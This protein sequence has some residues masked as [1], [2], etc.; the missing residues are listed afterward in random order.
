MLRVIALVSASMLA[1]LGCDS[2]PAQP[3]S[4]QAGSARAV[5]SQVA[6]PAG[7]AGSAGSTGSAGSAT[8]ASPKTAAEQVQQWAPAGTKVAPADLKVPGV[9]LFA[10]TA[11]GPGADDDAVELVGVAG[12][13]IV[14][15]RDLVQAAIAARPEPRILAHVALWA[16]GDDSDV[17]DAAA[18]RA[19]KAAKVRPPAIAKGALVFW[20]WT[21]DVPR[22]IGKARLD[23]ATGVLAIEPPKLPRAQVISNAMTTLGGTNSSRHA[24]ALKALGAVCAEPRARHALLGALASHPRIKTRV[25]A[26]DEARWCGAPAVDA[27]VTAMEQDKAAQVRA[28]AAGSLGRIGDARARPALAK[29]ARGDDANLAWAA[30][31]ALKK[32]Q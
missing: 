2:P 12:G 31:N 6:A 29:A 28:Q 25:A 26:A 16:L 27:L 21:R 10:L 18:S 7:S 17:L 19:Q 13:K 14:E 4:G 5:D 1:S 8:A 24:V 20:V 3:G 22:L 9:E 23:L 15:G 32:I 30:G 11:T